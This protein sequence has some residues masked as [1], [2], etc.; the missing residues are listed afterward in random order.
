M[1][2]RKLLDDIYYDEITAKKKLNTKFPAVT[3]RGLVNLINN[4]NKTAKMRKQAAI[5]L[6]RREEKKINIT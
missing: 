3:N 4:K 5:E 2:Y 6:K 1:N